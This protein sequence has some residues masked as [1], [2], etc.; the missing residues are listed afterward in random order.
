MGAER[1]GR[2]RCDV[3]GVSGPRTAELPVRKETSAALE[4]FDDPELELVARIAR[5]AGQRG[6]R[7]VGARRRREVQRTHAARPI[8]VGA[9]LGAE[10]R[11]ER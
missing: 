2:G 10:S 7:P 6:G 11:S 4:L 5:V 1:C 8:R 9:V 3:A